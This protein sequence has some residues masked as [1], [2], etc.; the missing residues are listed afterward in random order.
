MKKKIL[1]LLFVILSYNFIFFLQGLSNTELQVYFLGFRFNLFLLINLGVI[2]FNRSN[3][4]KLK[5]HFEKIGKFKY[6]L[7]AFLIPFI[8]SGL[9][10]LLILFLNSTIKFK[11]PEFLIEFGVSTLTDI[12]IYYLWNLPFLLSAMVVIILLLDDF[13][14]L[15]VWGTSLLL[16]LSFVLVLPISSFQKFDLRTF[17]F[18]PLIFGMIFY[19]LTIHKTF[20]SIWISVFSI[21]ISIYS[22]VLVFG[23]SNVF[24]IKTFFAR[25]YSNWSG[26]FVFKKFDVYLIDLF[27]SGLMILF[28][29][30][31]FIFDKKKTD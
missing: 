16:S 20:Q 4:V 27:Y 7:F 21:L 14:L 25:M 18:I 2:Y 12:P 1:T 26:L 19:N 13:K 5:T 9:T 11:K 6:W 23:S 22:F 31:F 3:F 24:I 29:L 10:L 17:S 15:K 8:T 30:L 28:A